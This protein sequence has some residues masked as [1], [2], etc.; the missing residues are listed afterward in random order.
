VKAQKYTLLIIDDD[1]DQRLLAKRTFEALATKYKVQLAAN[2]NEAIAYLKGEG[3][4]ADRK[5]FEFP[6]YILTDLKMTPGDGFHVLE[7]IKDHPALSIIP[8][9]MLS[10]SDD[11]DDIRQAYLLGASSF[12]VKPIGLAPLKALLRK[13]HDYWT[14]CEVPEVD[15]D[16]YAVQTNDTGRLGARYKK[17]KRGSSSKP[18]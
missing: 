8:V 5:K 11:A 18:S 16:G 2:G 14:E 13:I 9:V 1:P 7:F 3:A 6:S 15:M 17:P 4:F 10:S 12:F